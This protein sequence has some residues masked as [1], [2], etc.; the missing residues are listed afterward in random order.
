MKRVSSVAD[1]EM[2]YGRIW[3]RGVRQDEIDAH[4]KWRTPFSRL[5]NWLV[6]ETP[7]SMIGWHKPVPKETRWKLSAPFMGI[8]YKQQWGFNHYGIDMPYPKGTFVLAAGQ[9]VVEKVGLDDGV[10]W[11]RKS[12]RPFGN[13]VQIRHNKKFR[14]I[15][16]HM[17]TVDVIPGWFVASDYKLGTGDSTGWSTGDH[18]H[19][20]IQE[21]TWYGVWKYIDPMTKI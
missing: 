14:S 13:Y 17:E 2:W 3:H 9:G 20:S 7:E 10:R 1:I 19:F 5:I 11:P 6:D 18:L 4:L 12:R 15:Y 8:A 16:A 21:K